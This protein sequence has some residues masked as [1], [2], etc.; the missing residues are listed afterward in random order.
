MNRIVARDSSSSARRPWRRRGLARALIAR[1]LRLLQELGMEEA[2]LGVDAEN[3][4]SALRLY[5]SMG[6]RTVKQ[7]GT[8]RKALEFPGRH[9]DVWYGLGRLHAARRETAEARKAY[10]K[11]LEIQPACVQPTQV[12]K[13][14]DGKKQSEELALASERIRGR[15][16]AAVAC[17]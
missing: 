13:G 17:V 14:G 10:E 5:E 4:N 6:F 15:S 16:F 11:V 7:H 2:A 9:E 12:E 3:P 1:S 8:Y